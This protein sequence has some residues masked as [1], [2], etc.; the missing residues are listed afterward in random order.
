[1]TKLPPGVHWRLAP[2]SNVSRFEF[3]P[4]SLAL[5]ASSQTQT[6]PTGPRVPTPIKLFYGF[7]SVAYGVKDNGFSYLLLIFYNQVVGLP[8]EVVGAAIMIA[9]V[10]DAFLDPIV[11]QISDNW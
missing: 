7:G 2:F 3:S 5:A 6:H 11:G 8:A 10:F 9:L 4:G 1:M